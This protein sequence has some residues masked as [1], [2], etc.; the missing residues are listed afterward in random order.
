ML[1][2]VMA[3]MMPSTKTIIEM[4]VVVDPGGVVLILTPVCVLRFA[5]DCPLFAGVTCQCRRENH[6]GILKSSFCHDRTW[7]AAGFFGG[8]YDGER[9]PSCNVTRLMPRSGA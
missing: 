7:I 5:M 6:A 3:P 9:S 4:I 1:I 2:Q 8:V